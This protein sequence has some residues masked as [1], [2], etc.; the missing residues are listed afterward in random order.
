MSL[1]LGYAQLNFTRDKSYVIPHCHL[2][3]HYTHSSVTHCMAS[4]DRLTQAAAAGT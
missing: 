1:T 4:V 2:S 3:S